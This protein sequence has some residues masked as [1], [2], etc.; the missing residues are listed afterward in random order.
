MLEQLLDN[1]VAHDQHCMSIPALQAASKGLTNKKLVEPLAS[2][3]PHGRAR[4]GNRT[5]ASDVGGQCYAT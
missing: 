3:G 5:Q 2:R 1:R 4:T